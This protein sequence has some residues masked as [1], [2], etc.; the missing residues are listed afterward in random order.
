[1]YVFTDCNLSLFECL[2][3]LREAPLADVEVSW[4]FELKPR[5]RD[6]AEKIWWL[7]EYYSL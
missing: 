4:A 1:M 7:P 2:L 5:P 6:A 3:L